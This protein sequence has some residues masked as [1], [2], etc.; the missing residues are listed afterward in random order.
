MSNSGGWQEV[1]ASCSTCKAETPHRADS[2][3]KIHCTR[4]VGD[5]VPGITAPP[6]PPPPPP[7]A[8]VPIA[9]KAPSK[10]F[11]SVH[12][13]VVSGTLIAILVGVMGFTHVVHG[14]G[15]GLKI[16]AK[17]GWALGDTFVDLDDYI[18][19]PLLANIDKAKVLRAMFACEAL[20]RPDPEA[21]RAEREERAAERRAQRE[22]EQEE[23][24]QARLVENRAE[25]AARIRNLSSVKVSEANVDGDNLVIE[26][27]I[28]GKDR[29][30]TA[31]LEKVRRWIFGAEFDRLV[32]KNGAGE[33]PGR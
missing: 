7:L 4:C 10:G 20:A 6:P 13:L 15:V 11:V 33:I 25:T 21:G 8:P 9:T 12:R 28:S 3:G 5:N 22:R 31:H 17:D 27:V 18:G 26:A 16:C 30:S 1:L 24:E 32:C 2:E 23:R 19:K 14:G 29:C